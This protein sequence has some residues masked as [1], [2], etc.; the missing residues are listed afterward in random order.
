MPFGRTGLVAF[1]VLHRRRQIII[2]H[3]ILIG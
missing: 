2:E 1:V 3:V